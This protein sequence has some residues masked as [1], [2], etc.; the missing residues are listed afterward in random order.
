MCKSELAKGIRRLTGSSHRSGLG[1]TAS[2]Y[3]PKM[4]LNPNVF[5]VGIDA[6]TTNKNKAKKNTQLLFMAFLIMIA[7]HLTRLCSQLRSSFTEVTPTYKLRDSGLLVCANFC[8]C[9]VWYH[10]YSNIIVLWL[11]LIRPWSPP[12]LIR[13]IRHLCCTFFSPKYNA[14]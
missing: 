7:W 5:Y 3:H 8:F 4:Y 2:R 14:S 11:F 9:I 13:H 12:T 10:H 1:N 6:A